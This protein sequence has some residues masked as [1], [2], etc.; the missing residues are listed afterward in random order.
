MDALPEELIDNIISFVD[1][2]FTLAILARTSR[3]LYRLATPWLYGHVTFPSQTN[4]AVFSTRLHHVASFLIRRPDLAAIVEEVT[5]DQPLRPVDEFRVFDCD[6]LLD[7]DEVV[8]VAVDAL[9]TKGITDSSMVY[10]LRRNG[11]DAWLALL[12]AHLP[13]LKRLRRIVQM[14]A[15]DDYTRFVGLPPR[16]Q[17]FTPLEKLMLVGPVGLGGSLQSGRRA[18]PT[19]TLMVEPDAPTLDDDV[20]MERRSMIHVVP[21]LHALKPKALYIYN[22]YTDDNVIPDIPFT[23]SDLESMKRRMADTPEWLWLPTKHLEM[24]RVSLQ[25]EDVCTLLRECREVETIIFEHEGRSDLDIRRVALMLELH[26]DTLTRLLLNTFKSSG[27]PGIVCLRELTALKHLKIASTFIVDPGMNIS[28]LLPPNITT[29]SIVK[30][31]HQSIFLCSP[32]AAFLAVWQQFTPYLELVELEG[33]FALTGVY[34]GMVQ[35]ISAAE[36]S[37]VELRIIENAD[38]ELPG[39]DIIRPGT[40]G[41]WGM[42]ED[43]YWPSR[44]SQTKRRPPQPY[45]PKRRRRLLDLNAL[46]R[47]EGHELAAVIARAWGASH[48]S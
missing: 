20:D 11:D 16:K 12:L 21:H 41:G 2:R 25:D 30:P 37:G 7:L 29:L 34:R 24:R 23:R 35:C 15:G 6:E 9:A 17:P 40:E 33:W 22:M 48:S 46:K 3:Q 4:P 44:C 8:S 28:R 43:D 27:T 36:A 31:R 5:V 45:E 39:T 13:N 47:I 14:R 19:R 38:I 26:K 18:I 10:Y 42:E 1:H 32:I